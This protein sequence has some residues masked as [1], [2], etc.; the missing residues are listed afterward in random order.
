LGGLTLTPGVYDFSSSA[1]LTGTLT[2]DAEGDPNAQFIFKIGSTLTTASSSAV[3]LE[4]AASAG[5][6]VWQIGS[7]ATLGTDTTFAGDLLADQSITLTTGASLSGSAVALTGAVTLD[8]NA[9]S[10]DPASQDPAPVASTPEPSSFFSA[11]L[12]A[13]PG[14]GWWLIRRRSERKTLSEPRRAPGA[15]GQ[16]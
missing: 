3:I 1:Q 9:I 2:L 15:G 12:C 10:V 6:V 16:S 4:N 5:E 7:S 11:T 13:I 8:D 14:L